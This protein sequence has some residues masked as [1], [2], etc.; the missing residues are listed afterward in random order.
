MAE[1]Q[2]IAQLNAQLDELL[3]KNAHIELVNERLRDA[4]VLFRVKEERLLDTDRQFKVHKI[5]FEKNMIDVS[6]QIKSYEEDIENVK[7][8]CIKE[9]I[10]KEL[11]AIKDRLGA[12]TTDRDACT[13]AY[14]NKAID[15]LLEKGNAMFYSEKYED[16]IELY[17]QAM[18]IEQVKRKNATN[19]GCYCCFVSDCWNRLNRTEKAVD[20]MNKAISYDSVRP[21]YFHRRALIYYKMGMRNEAMIDLKMALSIDPG[22]VSSRHKLAELE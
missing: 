9:R 1:L 15:D 21:D 22:F 5:E 3:K 13:I 16:A 19:L 4:G 20:A 8:E 18:G 2:E 10:E 11:Q 6:N 12:T 17:M 7:A 14:Q